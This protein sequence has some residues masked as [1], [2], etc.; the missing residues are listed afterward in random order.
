MKF[1]DN[2]KAIKLLLKAF[3]KLETTGKTEYLLSILFYDENEKEKSCLYLNKS[4]EKGFFTPKGL[5]TIFCQKEY[6]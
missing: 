1:G 3:K 2:I 4:K 6:Y 5:E